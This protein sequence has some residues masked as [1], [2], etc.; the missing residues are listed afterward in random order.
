MSQTIGTPG[1]G[2]SLKVHIIVAT[3]HMKHGIVAYQRALPQ[4]MVALIVASARSQHLPITEQEAGIMA[5][6]GMQAGIFVKQSGIVPAHNQTAFLNGTHVSA[7][8]GKQQ[9]GR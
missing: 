9:P 5:H 7:H 8:W 6:E 2:I 4:N 3:Q 1:L